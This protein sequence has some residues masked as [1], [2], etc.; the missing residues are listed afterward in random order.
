MCLYAKRMSGVWRDQKRESHPLELETQMVV[1][2]G[3]LG[4]KAIL[5]GRIARDLKH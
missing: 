4:I 5:F 1:A 3:L 2:T